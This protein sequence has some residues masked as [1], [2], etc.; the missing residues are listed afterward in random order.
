MEAI[1]SSETSADLHRTIRRYI[2]ED[3]NLKRIPTLPKQNS[4]LL[5]HNQLWNIKRKDTKTPKSLVKS[6]KKYFQCKI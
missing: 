6:R 2:T 3:I 1:Y 5:I 4:R